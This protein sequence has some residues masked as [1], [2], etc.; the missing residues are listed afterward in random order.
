MKTPKI[1]EVN[2]P[3]ASTT[4]SFFRDQGATQGNSFLGKFFK[5]AGNNIQSQVQAGAL[6][7]NSQPTG[8]PQT[9]P[10]SGR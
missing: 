4:A 9:N 1:E 10:F 8:K 2:L 6:A 5:T 7:P 3:Y